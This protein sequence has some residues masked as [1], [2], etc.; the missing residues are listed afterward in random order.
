MKNIIQNYSTPPD[1]WENASEVARDTETIARITG[2][3]AHIQE[4]F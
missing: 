1:L 3:A 4:S 2:V